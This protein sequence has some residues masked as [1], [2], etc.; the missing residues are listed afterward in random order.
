MRFGELG[1]V[2]C[3]VLAFQI[4]ESPTGLTEIIESILNIISKTAANG[5]HAYMPSSFFLP[6]LTDRGAVVAVPTPASP[7]FFSH[8]LARTPRG[9]FARFPRLFFFS[10][11]SNPSTGVKH[12][13][14]RC[15]YHDFR[16]ALESFFSR[17]CQ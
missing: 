11:L 17:P 6:S 3:G 9:T 8:D 12:A 5:Q 13:A 4:A 10:A 15:Q 1:E 7:L 16:Y 2:R 14:L